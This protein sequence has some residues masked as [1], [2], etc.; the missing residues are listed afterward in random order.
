MHGFT[1][2]GHPVGGAIG[3]ANL[4]I[5]ENEGMV[6]NAAK[7]GPYLLER[8]RATVGDHDYVGDVRGEGLV[9]AVEFSRRQGDPAAV[10]GGHQPAPHRRAP[11]RWSST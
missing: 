2:S 1:Y 5:M 9:I 10:R 8:L 7:V 6:D 3:L 11:R 4:D